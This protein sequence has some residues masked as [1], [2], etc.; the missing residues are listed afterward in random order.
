MRTLYIE[1]AVLCATWIN[2]IGYS[3]SGTNRLQNAKKLVQKE[4]GWVIQNAYE[5]AF[6]E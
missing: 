6:A 1:L 4:T 2:Y 5:S 3:G